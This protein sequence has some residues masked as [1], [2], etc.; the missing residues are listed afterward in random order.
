MASD[1][2]L[3]STSVARRP[4]QLW[5]KGQSGNPKGRPRASEDLPALCRQYTAE[6]VQRLVQIM[7]SEDDDRALRAV[8]QLLDRGWGRPITPIVD[9]TEGTSLTLLHLIAARRV[10]EVLQAAMDGKA[11][12]ESGEAKAGTIDYTVPALE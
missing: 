10:G 9:E 6:A 2:Q 1:G 3:A 8:Q 12:P 7:R 4:G 11:E 5:Q